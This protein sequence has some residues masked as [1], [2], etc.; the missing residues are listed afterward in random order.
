M[1]GLPISP[2]VAPETESCMAAAVS[3]HRGAG[4]RKPRALRPRP[5]P[6]SHNKTFQG[7]GRG[8]RGRG[9]Q[10]AARGKVTSHPRDPARGAAP[11]APRRQKE[12]DAHRAGRPTRQRALS[13]QPSSA[14][15]CAP[16]RPGLGTRG[17]GARLA[18]LVSNREAASVRTWLRLEFHSG[19]RGTKKEMRVKKKKKSSPAMKQNQRPSH[20]A[21]KCPKQ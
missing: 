9:P 13:G 6:A 18:Y 19:Q 10:V 15:L 8:R 7:I 2:A 16:T 4:N 17:P 20:G 14:P 5:L 21:Q 3:A 12:R 1:A 11:P